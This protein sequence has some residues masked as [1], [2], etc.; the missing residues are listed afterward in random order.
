MAEMTTAKQ[1]IIAKLRE[2]EPGDFVMIDPETG[3]VQLRTMKLVDALEDVFNKA[4]SANYMAGARFGAKQMRTDI[5]TAIRNAN[6]GELADQ[7]E[8]VFTLEGEG[9]PE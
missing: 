6:G 9:P 5:V 7:L 4:L 8:Q 2:Q 3:E 1:Q